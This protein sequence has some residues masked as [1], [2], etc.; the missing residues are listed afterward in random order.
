[1]YTQ[2]QLRASDACKD[3]LLE[4]FEHFDVEVFEHYDATQLNKATIVLKEELPRRGG[5]LMICVSRDE[6]PIYSLTLIKDEVSIPLGG[7]RDRGGV[8]LAYVREVRSAALN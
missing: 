8:I 5:H 3:K 7:Y 6:S 2:K 1:M 4:I